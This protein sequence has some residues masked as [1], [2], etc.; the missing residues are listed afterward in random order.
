MIQREVMAGRIKRKAVS[1]KTKYLIFTVAMLLASCGNIVHHQFES[2]DSSGWAVNDTL[3]YLYEGTDRPL[4]GDALEL[5]LQLCYTADFKYNGLRV[6]VETL[7]MCDSTLL[8]VDTLQCQMYDS[9]GRHLGRTAG[10]LY[11][12]NGSST[13]LDAVPSDTLMF[14]ISHVMTHRDVVGVTDVGIKVSSVKR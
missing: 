5:V 12:I 13:I 1:L 3:C 2:V 4:Q 9:D 6:R 11:Q 14:R 8:S 10:T 7:K